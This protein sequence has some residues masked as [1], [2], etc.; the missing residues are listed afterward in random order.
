VEPVG[1]EDHFFALGGHSLLATQAVSRLRT[2]LQVELPLRAFLEAPTVA[3]IA[4]AVAGLGEGSDMN[5]VAAVV[6]ELNELSE[7]DVQRMLAERAGTL[8]E[9]AS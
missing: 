4:A 9:T 1:A 8:E 5:E 7:D 6:L 2:L 3:G